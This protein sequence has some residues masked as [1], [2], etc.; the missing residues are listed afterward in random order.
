MKTYEEKINAIIEYF[1]NNEETFNDCIEE[2][3]SYNGYLGDDRYYYM[4][5]LDEL[6]SGVSA[7]EI[8]QRAFFGGDEDGGTE[9]NPN[10]DYFRYNGYGNLVSSNYKDYSAHLDHYAIE[11]MK[12]NRNQIDSIEADDELSKLF[13]ALEKDEEEELDEAFDEFCAIHDCDTCKFKDC[14]T[15]TDCFQGFK[16]DLNAESE[17]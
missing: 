8:L 10:S 14:R 9:F 15:V 11:E 5:E 17:E 16:A 2:L 6:Y 1:E 13:D 7:T 3:D 12:E 4:E